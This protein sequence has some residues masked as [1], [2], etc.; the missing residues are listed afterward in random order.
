VPAAYRTFFKDPVSGLDF[1]FAGAM[2]F[3]P[4]TMRRSAYLDIGGID[5]G[6]GEPGQC[7]IMSDWELSSRM[8]LAGWQMGYTWLSMQGDGATGGWGWLAFEHVIWSRV[9]I[10]DYFASVQLRD[11]VQ[12]WSVCL[13]VSRVGGGVG[14]GW[15][16]SCGRWCRWPQQGFV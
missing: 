16:C 3:A 12:L 1:Q 14:W 7:A 2:D 4:M 11:R 5:E 8:W 9:W 13:C 10:S 15:G 6:M